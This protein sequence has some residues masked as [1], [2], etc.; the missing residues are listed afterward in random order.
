MLRIAN[1]RED[2]LDRGSALEGSLDQS[3]QSVCGDPKRRY[4]LRSDGSLAVSV[5]GKSPQHEVIEGSWGVVVTEGPWSTIAVRGRQWSADG[6]WDAAGGGLRDVVGTF[7]VATV[8][9]LGKSGL[10]AVMKAWAETRADRVDCLTV[11]LGAWD[12]AFDALVAGHAL[13]VRGQ[14]ADKAPFEDLVWHP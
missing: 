7:Q 4:K 10:G 9:T 8:G 11:E 2:D 13:V 14:G 5:F 1:E 6:R 3:W 12:D